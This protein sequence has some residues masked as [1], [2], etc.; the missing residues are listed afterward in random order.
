[1]VWGEAAAVSAL[2]FTDLEVLGTTRVDDVARAR[3]YVAARRVICLHC[4]E[5]AAER[6]VSVYRAPKQRLWDVPV[7]RLVQLGASNQRLREALG[8]CDTLCRRC[9]LA[10]L[11]KPAV[12]KF[13]RPKMLRC[14]LD[15]FHWGSGERLD[16][17]RWGA[18]AY[19]RRLTRNDR[20]LLNGNS[21]LT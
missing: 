7:A 4:G 21:L 12:L 6:L 20:R 1:V 9:H 2:P 16:H 3:A 19:S 13:P 5:D 11:N 8:K 10:R 14:G 17:Q 18:K 15:P